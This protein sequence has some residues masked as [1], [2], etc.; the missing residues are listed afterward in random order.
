MWDLRIYADLEPEYLPPRF[1]EVERGAVHTTDNSAN[2]NCT[3]HTTPNPTHASRF[4]S[5]TTATPSFFDRDFDL[6][7]CPRRRASREQ[8]L[9]GRN[10][11]PVH[12]GGGRGAAQGGRNPP[13]PKSK[14]GRTPLPLEVNGQSGAHINIVLLAMFQVLRTFQNLMTS[15]N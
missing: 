3:C 2:S 15:N 10:N 9:S 1:L 5:A 7:N 14:V 4:R 11:A 13:T 12:S 8:A 6:P